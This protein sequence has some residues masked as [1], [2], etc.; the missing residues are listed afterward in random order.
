MAGRLPRP[1][2]LSQQREQLIDQKRFA[3]VFECSGGYRGC[4]CLDA[5]V[6]RY[7]HTLA[8]G[9]HIFQFFEEFETVGL[10][11]I[12]I[13]KCQI[14]AA[15]TKKWF[16]FL[17]TSRCK[18]FVAFCSQNGIQPSAN[19]FVIIHD[20][21]SEWLIHTHIR[22]DP[23]FTQDSLN[24]FIASPRNDTQRSPAQ[25]VPGTL[26]C[27]APNE[28]RYSPRQFAVSPARSGSS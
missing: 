17:N 21:Y 15:F 23:L 16:G 20:E 4:R 6:R 2:Q 22:S 25:L 27:S 28:S 11:N 7:H 3:H 1:C 8:F 13:Q 14:D 12:D 10:S 9:M 18:A 24:C 26:P 5:G 19:G